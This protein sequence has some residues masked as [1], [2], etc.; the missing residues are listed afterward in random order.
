[1]QSCI[2]LLQGFEDGILDKH[3][4][5]T[6]QS[7]LKCPLK[8]LLKLPVRSPC[9]KHDPFFTRNKTSIQKTDA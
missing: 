2:G 3:H 8:N 5:R 4:L 7:T 1:M 6:R 9:Q